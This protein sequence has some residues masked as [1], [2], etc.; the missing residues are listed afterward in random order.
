MELEL[1]AFL[2]SALDG[3]EWSDSRPARYTTGERAPGTRWIGGWIAPRAG[4]DAW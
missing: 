2:I 3:G 4:L 1:H